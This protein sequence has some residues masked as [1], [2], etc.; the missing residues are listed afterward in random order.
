MTHAHSTDH[1]QTLRFTKV[2]LKTYFQQRRRHPPDLISRLLVEGRGSDLE[3]EDEDV[4][5]HEEVALAGEQ[6]EAEE[7]VVAPA[8]ADLKVGR[9]LPHDVLARVARQVVHHLDA[10]LVPESGSDRH[11]RLAPTDPLQSTS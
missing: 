11:Q 4:H 8:L 2:V 5:R 10:V 7:T 9:E 3:A 6:I 1:T